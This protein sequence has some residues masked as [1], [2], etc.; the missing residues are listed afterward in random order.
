MNRRQFFQALG[1]ALALPHEPKTIYSFPTVVKEAPTP[2]WL[3]LEYAK[4]LRDTPLLGRQPWPWH[5]Y[6]ASEPV[7]VGR[8]PE[9][10]DYF[11]N[12]A[13]PSPESQVTVA[14]LMALSREVMLAAILKQVVVPEPGFY[15]ITSPHPMSRIYAKVEFNHGL[16]ALKAHALRGPHREHEGGRVLG[17]PEAHHPHGNQFDVEEDE[18]PVLVL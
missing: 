18:V 13:L 4:K 2:E 9:R 12:Q 11:T 14:Q 7:F 1:S 5:M 10:Q 8:I 6:E 17:R 16:P 3:M 15:T